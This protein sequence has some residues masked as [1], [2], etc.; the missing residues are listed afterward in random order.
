MIIYLHNLC[1]SITKKN[2][3]LHIL[4]LSPLKYKKKKY[5]LVINILIIKNEMIS[6]NKYQ[7]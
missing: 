1:F 5:E 7:N 2:N 6:R 3:F 4:S